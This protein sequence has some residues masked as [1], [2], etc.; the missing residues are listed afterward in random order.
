MMGPFASKHQTSKETCTTQQ[1]SREESIPE[2]TNKVKR[3]IYVQEA[4]QRV[5]TDELYNSLYN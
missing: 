2:A 1:N 4:I 3:H 5:N